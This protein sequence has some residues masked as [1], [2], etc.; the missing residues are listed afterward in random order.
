MSAWGPTG[1]M[2]LTSEGLSMS[3]SLC[4]L[5]FVGDSFD[6]DCREVA[7]MSSVFVCWGLKEKRGQASEFAVLY[8]IT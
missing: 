8:F 5:A 7:E 4:T 1:P 2:S 6:V 3:I